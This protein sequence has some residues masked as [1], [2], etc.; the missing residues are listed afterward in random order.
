MANI[1]NTIE[2][3]SLSNGV[4]NW[5]T[6]SN[7]SYNSNGEYTTLTCNVNGTG[8]LPTYQAFNVT[9]QF[10]DTNQVLYIT[11]TVRAPTT[12][13]SYPRVYIS[14]YPNGVIENL[15]YYN[16][17]CEN[18]GEWH[19]LTT[20]L[21]TYNS[22]TGN[23][24]D[25]V[26]IAF[27]ILDSTQG[28]AMDIKN[29]GVYNLTQIFG[30][31][32]EPTKKWCDK[33]LNYGIEYI[34]YA[35]LTDLIFDRTKLDIENETLKGFYNYNDLN[36]I[37]IWCDYLAGKLTEFGYPVSI[38]TKKD[39]SMRDFPTQ[40]QMNRVREN[41]Q[42]LKNAF[43]SVTNVPTSQYMTWQKANQFEKV[44]DEIDS[45]L[46][47]T[48]DYFVYMGVANM[49]QNRIWQNRFRRR[50]NT[51]TYNIWNDLDEIYWNEFNENQTW[52]GVII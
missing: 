52:N 11:A 7:Y 37:E 13:T 46:T 15:T 51:Y 14:E 4:E 43:S 19:T 20:Q 21:K 29:V 35:P 49:G 5:T 12:N 28:D 27:G 32:N 26:R 47:G 16:L 41:I 33:Y 2:N 39:W 44:L 31:D 6:N 8:T 9:G 23:Y 17:T 42:A 22:N 38:V 1:V 10:E 30:R 18:D 25:Y 24:Y 50:I 40:A 3:G 48:I 34:E 45:R 36:R